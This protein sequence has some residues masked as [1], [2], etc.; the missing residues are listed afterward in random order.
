MKPQNMLVIMSDEHNA[1]MMGAVGHRLARTPNL[2]ALAARGALFSDAYTNCPI[3]VPARATFATGR[4]VHDTEYW[5]NSIAY[6]GRVPSWG[7]RLQQAGIRV[8]SIGKLHYRNETDDTGF[9]AQ[10]IPMHIAGGVGM[11]HFSI[12]RQFKDFVRPAGRRSA[13]IEHAG[14]GESEYTRYDRKVADIATQ[15][16]QDAANA[17]KPWTLFVSFVTP[18]YPLIAPKEYCDLYPVEEMPDAKF[19]PE[20]GFQCHPWLEELVA[21]SVMTKDQQRAA[22]SAYL[23][24]VSFMDAQVGRV[25]DALDAAGLRDTTRILYTSDHGENAGA[26]GMWGKS[27]HYEEAVR[28]PLILAGSDVPAGKVVHTPVSLVDVYPTILEGVGAPAAEQ[29]LPGRSLFAVLNEPDDPARAVFSEYHAAGSPSASYMLRKGRYKLIWYV[30][31]APELFDLE[32]DPEETRNIAGDPEHAAIF[33]QLEAALR[34]I[35]D[36]ETEDARANEAQRKLIESKGGPQEVMAK[37]AM[38]KLYTPVPGGT[39]S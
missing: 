8:E 6:D 16:L 34:E 27:N 19:G 29:D 32:S 26:R 14:P 31:Y 24:L 15:W 3:C 33:R 37:L 22:F 38:K 21:S 20:S 7:H 36:P 9:D 4:Y 12:R 35:V 2:D 17:D 23:G 1:R 28:I 25:L 11:I 5:D 18:H 30:G 39:I 13:I 10:H